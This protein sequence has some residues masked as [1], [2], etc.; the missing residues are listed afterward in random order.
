[1]D[2][3]QLRR[4]RLRK[5]LRKA[6]VDS[7]LVTNFTN[8]TYLTG[9]TGD[10]SYLLD[11]AGPAGNPQRSALYHPVGRGVPRHRTG[12][13]RDRQDHARHDRRGA[14]PGGR[15]DRSASKPAR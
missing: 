8:V 14:R 10:D 4:D 2:S 11:R 5:L 12:D 1:M 15:R 7:L 3:Y 13:S 9:F 6:G